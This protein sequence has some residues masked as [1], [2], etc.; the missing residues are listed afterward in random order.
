MQQENTVLK[1]NHIHPCVILQVSTLCRLQ[2]LIDF[3]FS[4]STCVT[5]ER[6]LNSKG[7]FVH[8]K[9]IWYRRNKHFFFLYYPLITHLVSH[10][11]G[12]LRF[13]CMYYL[14]YQQSK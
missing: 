13:I 5:K 1:R 7:C 2:Y 12:L 4:V 14:G 6:K 11:H 8:P 10:I 3:L 9:A